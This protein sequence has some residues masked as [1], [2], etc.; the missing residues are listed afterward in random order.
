MAEKDIVDEYLAHHGIRGQKWGVR[1]TQAS[2]ARA[3]E[4]VKKANELDPD[5]L[6][7]SG[8]GRKARVQS[9][10]AARAATLASVARKHG[11]S[12][13]SNKD[14]EFLNK[15]LQLN[16]QYTKLTPVQKSKVARVIDTVNKLDRKTGRVASNAIKGA[17]VKGVDKKTN[18]KGTEI[19]EILD[20]VAAQAKPPK[21]KS[22]PEPPKQVVIEEGKDPLVVV[23]SSRRPPK[24]VYD[25]STKEWKVVD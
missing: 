12:T 10:E 23:L 17:I 7:V 4:G 13:L 16:A 6:Y 2:L 20:K 18:G 15:R 5:K 24:E 19:K 25:T 14:L 3:S 8:K 1:R 22:N 11:T 9:G 21:Q